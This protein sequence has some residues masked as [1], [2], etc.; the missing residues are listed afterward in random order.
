MIR[1]VLMCAAQWILW[2]AGM[3]VLCA[4]LEIVP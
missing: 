2:V 1:L 4:G 3:V